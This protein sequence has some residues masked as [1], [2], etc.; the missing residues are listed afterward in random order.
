MMLC[1]ALV[2]TLHRLYSLF[3]LCSVIVVV[4]TIVLLCFLLCVWVCGS[5]IKALLIKNA[6]GQKK[7]TWWIDIFLL[8]DF[9]TQILISAYFNKREFMIGWFLIL[10]Y[11]KAY[12]SN[13][14]FI[15]RSGGEMKTF[16][17][18]EDKRILRHFQQKHL[19]QFDAN[20]KRY[21]IHQFIMELNVIKLRLCT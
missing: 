5:A 11:W 21:L 10:L 4:V 14:L 15:I 1:C 9:W 2:N 18:I 19:R 13:G 17:L 3:S 7:Q 12:F 8:N 20:H 16:L 6:K